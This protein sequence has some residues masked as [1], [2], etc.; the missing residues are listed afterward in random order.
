VRLTV[1]E[2]RLTQRHIWRS[3]RGEISAQPGLVVEATHDRATG[4]GE[5]AVFMTA[6][7][8]SSLPQM[9]ADLRRVAPRFAV[10][11]PR[12]DPAAAWQILSALLPGSPFLLAALDTALHDLHAR[13]MGTPLWQSLGLSRP[14]RLRSSFSVGIDSVPVMVAKL[15]E[16]PGWPAYKIKIPDPGDLSALRAL[17]EQTS[18]PFYVDGNG[19]WEPSRTRTAL[20]PLYALGVRLLEQPYPRDRWS[21]AAALK[22]ASPFPVI[23]DE[24][25]TGPADLEPCAW[26][27]HGINV[28]PMKVGGITPAL[29]ILRQARQRGLITMVGCVMESAASVSA[30]AHL[31]GLADYLDLDILDLLAVDTGAGAELGAVGQLQ[32]PDRLGT[33]YRPDPDA[34][35]WS[36]L[37]TSVSPF[38]AA[39]YFAALRDGRVT[40]RVM[41]HPEAPPGLPARLGPGDA[42]WRVRDLGGGEDHD[43]EAA[44]GLLRSALTHAVLAGAARVRCQ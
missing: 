21:A 28:K 23:A 27:F 19:A 35:G 40:G 14:A 16:R 24:S 7:Y 26:A 1:H 33:G 6:S 15:R 36:I 11:D 22:A 5:A 10:V 4:F 41:V 43:A 18:A 20:E 25:M 2:V 31:G 12:D 30:T 29:A 8:R 38:P 42:A 32:V 39:R 9:H 17:R 44:A 13:L 3:A 34:R 37:G